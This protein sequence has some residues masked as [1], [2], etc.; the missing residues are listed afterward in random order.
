MIHPRTVAVVL[1]THNRPIT[2]LKRALDSVFRQTYVPFKIVVADT[3][4]APEVS[5][6]ITDYIGSLDRSDL[7]LISLPGRSNNYGRNRGAGSVGGDYIAFL[8][9]DDEWFP[10]KLESQIR[11]MDDNIS[12]IYSNYVVEDKR[13]DIISRFDRMPESD[14]FEIR[15]LGE[16]IIGCTSMPLLSRKA[17]YEAGCFDESIESNQEWDLWIRIL[18]KHD[19][20]YCPEIAGIKHYSTES[21]SNARRRRAAGWV[22]LLMK[23]ADKYIK[24]PEQL[25]IA[26]GF[27]SREMFGK[28]MYLTGMV[29]FMA[30]VVLRVTCMKKDGGE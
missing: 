13:E 25:A 18:Q 6:A 26:T 11:M 5:S 10:R 29:A 28:K 17:F 24:N 1:T 19:V 21:I 8:D 20:K 30:H 27:F 14:R 22:R 2:I 23:H 7:E 3:S 9:D 12:M 4:T 16:N 15:I